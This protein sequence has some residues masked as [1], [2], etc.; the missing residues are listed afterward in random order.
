MRALFPVVIKAASTLKIDQDLV[1]ELQA[2]IPS[3]PLLPE[4]NPDQ[5]AL[6][7]EGDSHDHSIIAIPTLLMP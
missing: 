5:S 1:K 4:R 7:K 3:L 2:A 6:L